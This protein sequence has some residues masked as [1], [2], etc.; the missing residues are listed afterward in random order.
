MR[1]AC[2]PLVVDDY[3]QRCCAHVFKI[4]SDDPSARHA[5]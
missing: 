2:A 4:I 5:I 3:A 1:V